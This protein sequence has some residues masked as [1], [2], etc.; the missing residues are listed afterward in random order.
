MAS[1]K[2]VLAN[3]VF[4]IWHIGHLRHL[5]AARRFGDW[6]VVSITK[7]AYVRK[8]PRRPVFSDSQRRE[9]VAA[10]NCV[11]RTILVESALEA[12][13]IV[14]PQV[15]V[16][17]WDYKHRMEQEHVDY[18]KAHGIEIAFTNEPQYSSTDLLHYYDKPRS[19]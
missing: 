16:K 8:G 9:V 17:G 11:D 6:L 5:Q 12:L 7:D 13:E 2:I 10:Q 19:S 18:C 4:D 15:F 1:S 3:G 14:R